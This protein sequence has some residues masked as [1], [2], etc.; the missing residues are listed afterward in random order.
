MIAMLIGLLVQIDMMNLSWKSKN[1]VVGLATKYFSVLRGTYSVIHSIKVFVE[2]F[3]KINILHQFGA[4]LTR[5]GVS[6]FKNFG[7]SG[8]RP[9]FSFVKKILI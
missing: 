3:N 1:N 8:H 7:P 6:K 9:P 4:G 5:G 2:H